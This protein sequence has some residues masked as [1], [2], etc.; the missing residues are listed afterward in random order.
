MQKQT[1][2]ILLLVLLLG[3][4][5][6]S[7]VYRDL[8]KRLASELQVSL[9][10]QSRL[11]QW[12]ETRDCKS[13]KTELS[14]Q[15]LRDRIYGDAAIVFDT[16]TT[17][18]MVDLM[19]EHLLQSHKGACVSIS[20]LALLLAERSGIA[21]QVIS[22]PGHVFLRFS[23]NENWESNRSGYRYRDEE[24][25]AKYSIS[26][27]QLK[28]LTPKQFEG[29]FRYEL[30]NRSAASGDAVV[31]S[32]FYM[33]AYGLW[34]DPSVAGNWALLLEKMGQRQKA[35]SILDRLWQ[36]GVRSEDLVW[37]KALMMLRAEQPAT[38]VLAFLQS[39]REASIVSAR[40]MDLDMRI[41]KSQE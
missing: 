9:Q 29:V 15:C 25:L 6:F 11:E 23:G 3:T 20:F 4:Q 39:A 32:R 36:Q 19:P 27:E 37:N 8:Y 10:D 34:Q 2:G 7:G 21:V 28:P 12:L 18:A 17:R 24:Y 22:V 26:A 41:R 14:I 31:A 16:I 5:A 38:Q 13:P 33:Q 1:R 35:I 40:L 30:G